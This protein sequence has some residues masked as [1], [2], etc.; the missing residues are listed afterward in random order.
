MKRSY[1]ANRRDVDEDLH[2][3]LILSPVSTAGFVH[4]HFWENV[5]LAELGLALLGAD[6]LLIDLVDVRSTWS[7]IQ[8]LHEFVKSALGALSFSN[9]LEQ[10][11]LLCTD[12]HI[13]AWPELP[14]H[15]RRS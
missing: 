8:M 12:R 7:N 3:L 15:R 11:Q 9:D 4:A 5:S 6:V 1:D 14:F 13:S 10:H 2:Y